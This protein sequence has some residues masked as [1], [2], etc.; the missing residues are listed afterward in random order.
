MKLR[1]VSCIAIPEMER[2]N[3]LCLMKE[4]LSKKKEKKCKYAHVMARK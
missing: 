1:L 4:L 2:I 3:K